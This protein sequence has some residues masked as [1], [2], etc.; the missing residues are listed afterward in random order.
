MKTAGCLAA[1]QAALRPAQG[2]SSHQLVPSPL[3]HRFDD[4][5]AVDATAQLLLRVRPSVSATPQVGGGHS[6]ADVR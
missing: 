1:D 4:V 5:T 2:S 6:A 3:S